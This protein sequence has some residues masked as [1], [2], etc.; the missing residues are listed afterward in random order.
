MSPLSDCFE[1][2]CVHDILLEYKQE[3]LAV[4]LK[5]RVAGCL[6]VVSKTVKIFYN[7][8]DWWILYPC[9]LKDCYLVCCLFNFTMKWRC[10]LYQ[11]YVNLYFPAGFTKI[12][13]LFIYL[14]HFI[15]Q[16][17]P[18]HVPLETEIRE[19]SCVLTPGYHYVAGRVHEI[20]GNKYRVE[21]LV[22]A[23][24]DYK[25]QTIRLHSFEREKLRVIFSAWCGKHCIYIVLLFMT[26]NNLRGFSQF[27][28][29]NNSI[30][31]NK[32]EP[33]SYRNNFYS[34]QRSPFTLSF[35][36]STLS[37]LISKPIC[38]TRIKVWCVR[39]CLHKG[40]G[41]GGGGG[42]GRGGG[43][44]GGGPCMRWVG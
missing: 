15:F 12:I 42:R 33:R 4:K 35:L 25:G 8:S 1:N 36:L 18:S 39:A 27:V 44:G 5:T 28:F 16:V 14:F 6:F 3:C 37:L 21:K 20:N 24:R 31:N 2:D 17:I 26:W 32:K 19:N 29:F 7:Q 43:G 23:N 38:L 10:H 34:L 9:P 41:G 30:L 22:D 40:L 11:F 13:Y